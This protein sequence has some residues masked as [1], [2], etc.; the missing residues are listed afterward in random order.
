V[1]VSKHR[2]QLAVGVIEQ[3][4][5]ATRGAASRQRPA[6]DRHLTPVMSFVVAV[7]F[8]AVQPRSSLHRAVTSRSTPE[9]GDQAA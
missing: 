1:P 3:M 4:R 9:S 6:I 7:P 8:L 2:R 5:P